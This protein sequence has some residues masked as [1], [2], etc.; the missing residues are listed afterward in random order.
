MKIEYN[1]R[2]H[3]RKIHVKKRIDDGA[4]RMV[5]NCRK[6]LAAA[7]ALATDQAVAFSDFTAA[8][9]GTKPATDDKI[10]AIVDAKIS[11]IM[12]GMQDAAKRDKLDF[13]YTA[14]ISSSGEK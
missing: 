4:W 6:I 2:Q 11:P 9:T 8:A 13:A 12:K 10:R 7:R 3:G 14:S 1:V 5:A